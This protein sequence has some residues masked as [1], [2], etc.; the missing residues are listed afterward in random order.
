MKR[1]RRSPDKLYKYLGPAGFIA[2]D[3]LTIRFTRPMDLNDP[4]E[5]R[6]PA[7]ITSSSGGLSYGIS[8]HGETGVLSP[9]QRNVLMSINEK[10]GISCFS[11]TPDNL[12]M[13]AHYGQSHTGLVVAFNAGHPSFKGLGD[14]IPVTYGHARPRIRLTGKDSELLRAFRAKSQEWSYEREWRLI[15][16]LT[17]CP[18]HDAL[19]LKSI[20]PTAIVAVFLG[21]NADNDLT[22]RVK[23]WQRKYPK[24]ELLRYRLDS[25]D[26]RLFADTNVHHEPDLVSVSDKPDS[27]LVV[28]P[29]SDRFSVGVVEFTPEGVLVRD[30]T[31][32]LL[33][34][35]KKPRSDKT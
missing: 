16:S 1:P 28:T 2:L 34:Q 7:F 26:F 20:D 24:V 35:S 18:V 9:P 29:S 23:C 33:K 14:L 11:E 6:T 22:T 4:F 8:T 21:A 10:Y 27:Y 15:T 3:S 17:S 32:R 5:A 31:D 30:H 25:F 19:Y 13:W 12:L